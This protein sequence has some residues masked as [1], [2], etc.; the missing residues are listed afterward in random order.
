MTLDFSPTSFYIVI[1]RG[2][3]E[4]MHLVV[5]VRLSVRPFV[6]A[7]TAERFDLRP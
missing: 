4:I 5:S 1:G 3:K 7:L 2:A 6:C